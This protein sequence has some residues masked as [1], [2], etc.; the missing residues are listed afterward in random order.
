MFQHTQSLEI[1]NS[2]AVATS[3]P[4]P[5]KTG[6]KILRI[7]YIETTITLHRRIKKRAQYRMCIDIYMYTCTYAH[8]H[9]HVHTHMIEYRKRGCSFFF[10][11]CANKVL[12]H[13]T[14]SHRDTPRAY[15]K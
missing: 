10:M 3:P 5:P 9:A 6:S 4:S 7:S 14:N 12:P 13:T 2:M 8:A 15:V 11:R 1:T